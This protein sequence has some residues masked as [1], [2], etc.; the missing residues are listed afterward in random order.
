MPA[1]R[2]DQSSLGSEPFAVI[3]VT[4]SPAKSFNNCDVHHN[5][6]NCGDESCSPRTRLMSHMLRQGARALAKEVTKPDPSMWF[7]R[8]ELRLPFLSR[9]SSQNR[10]MENSK[11][12]S[13]VPGNQ[14]V[15]PRLNPAQ[16]VHHPPQHLAYPSPT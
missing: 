7:R 5:V 15:D 16:R 14:M 10:P 9:P 3:P 2:M 8:G 1:R 12:S 13:G 4:D 6:T 11:A